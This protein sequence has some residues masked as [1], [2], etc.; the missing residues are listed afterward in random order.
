AI[1][2]TLAS[3]KSPT[4][5]VSWH[6]LKSYSIILNASQSLEQMVSLRFCNDTVNIL[7]AHEGLEVIEIKRI[8]LNMII[9]IEQSLKT[10]VSQMLDM[11][12]QPDLS[13]I[14]HVLI[15]CQRLFEAIGFHFLPSDTIDLS[16][17]LTLIRKTVL[18][19]D[20]ALI[21]YVRSHASGMDSINFNW[22]YDCLEIS[23]ADNTLAIRCSWVGL[24]CLDSFLDRR[25]VWVFHLFRKS[26]NIPSPKQKGQSTDP[27]SVLAR[28]EDLADIWGPVYCVPSR[29][30]LVK[31]YSVSKG[32]I[33]RVKTKKQSAI[34]GAVQCHYFTRLSFFRKRASRLLF[35]DEDLPL[36]K[37]DLLLIGTGL[38]ENPGCQYTISAFTQ[39]FASQV[40]PLG[41]RDSVWKTDSR[42]LTIGLSK[43]LG[44]TVSG[45]QKLVPQTTLKQQI[46]D[47]WTMKPSRSNPGILNQTFGVEVGH[48]TGNA[49]RI[50]LRE[51]MISNAI[52]PILE[53]Q[54]PNWVQTSWGSALSTALHSI[55]P[56][57][58]FGVW[59][60]FKLYRGEIAELVCYV[61]EIL[62][63]TG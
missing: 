38:Y 60:D 51:L 1:D 7:L 56:E 22:D 50:S 47:K 49:R 6:L 42:G 4:Y 18:L 10:A 54:N 45:T 36:S 9:E 25:R 21:S 58:I 16:A 43:Y 8:P 57:E 29:A 15:L 23:D 62:D 40:T 46:L 2:D 39:D 5:D 44:V 48:C 55:D 11:I 63:S 17:K 59:R 35:G 32:V 14:D 3:S 61:L 19:V 30:G 24:S 41:T 27:V 13:L 53:R 52:W 37:G 26:S 34:P 31:Y 28:I 12:D 33:C 20:N